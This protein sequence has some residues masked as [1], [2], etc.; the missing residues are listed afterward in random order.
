MK[1]GDRCTLIVAVDTG[2]FPHGIDVPADAMR[3]MPEVPW[4]GDDILIGEDGHPWPPTPE[5]GVWRLVVEYQYEP[6]ATYQTE[7]GTECVEP[8]E[9]F[10]VIEATKLELV[11]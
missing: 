3:H 8:D 7:D 1:P 10:A 9:W 2:G 11:G 4:L 6:G 5:S